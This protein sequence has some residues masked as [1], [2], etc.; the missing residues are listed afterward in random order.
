[1]WPFRR[2]KGMIRPNMALDYEGSR[3]IAERKTIFMVEYLRARR[4][5]DRRLIAKYRRW[6]LEGMQRWRAV[7]RA[8][9][10]KEPPR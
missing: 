8:T 5:P 4:D 9:P 6:H 7:H 2:F 10:S 1:M 3:K